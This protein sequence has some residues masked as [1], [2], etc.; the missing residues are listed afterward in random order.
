M[1]SGQII[2]RS[3]GTWLV[4][5]YH[6]RDPATG[7]RRYI[8]KTVRGD[9]PAAEA[10]LAR[11]AALVPARPEKNSKLDRYLDWWLYAAVDGR[12]RAKTARD[13]R[14]L[15]DR[16]VLP[17]LGDTRIDRL[18]P[19]DLQSL[20]LNMT[21]RGLS[22]RTVRYTHAVLRSALDQARRWKLLNENPSL[23]MPLPRADRKEFPVFSRQEA[24]RFASE[25]RRDTQALVFLVALTTGLRPSEYLAIRISDFDSARSTLTITR[26]LERAKGKWT[27]AE[28]K[29]PGSRRTVALPAE[30]AELV[31]DRIASHAFKPDDLIFQG[32]ARGPIHERN[33]VQRCFKP[34]LRRAGLPNLRLY[35]LRHSFATLALR[36]GVPARLVSEQLGHA[37]VAFTLDV[38]GHV[39]EETRSAG[40][41]RLS[42]LLF[43]PSCKSAEHETANESDRKP[44]QS[45]GA[46]PNQKFA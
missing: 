44:I 45:E 6:G 16:Y 21:A 29:R 42:Q 32:A 15:L 34:L 43:P 11:L 4:R 36:E 8:N 35:D 3:S 31:R 25:C 13:Y 40:A 41:E 24:Q 30:V 22:P 46:E 38:Y 18:R 19:L 12:L 27:F 14:T 23:D 7:K 10:E 26:T 28:T 20:L 37:S 39:L 5:L 33:L 1:P 17:V 9:R 2:A